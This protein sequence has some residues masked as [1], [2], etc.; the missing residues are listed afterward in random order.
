MIAFHIEMLR[1]SFLRSQ[2]IYLCDHSN[3]D[4]VFQHNLGYK[5][6]QQIS[7]HYTRLSTDSIQKGS[8]CS[9]N[10][11]N[12]STATEYMYIRSISIGTRVPDDEHPHHLATGDHLHTTNHSSSPKVDL[13]FVSSSCLL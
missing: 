11:T 7:S 13:V 3:W 10:G 12:F 2:N 5:Q 4:A 9:A 1:A 8:L 6:K